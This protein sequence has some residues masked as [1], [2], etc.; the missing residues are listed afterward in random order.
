VLRAI[1]R[2][3]RRPDPMLRCVVPEVT[4]WRARLIVRVPGVQELV[5]RGGGRAGGQQNGR[6][7]ARYARA[8]EPQHEIQA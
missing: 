2:R 3:L 5:E 8:E 1:F 4:R 6:D 7:Q